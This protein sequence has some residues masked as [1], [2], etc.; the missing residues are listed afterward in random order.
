M[1]PANTRTININ[2]VKYNGQQHYIPMNFGSKKEG[3]DLKKLQENQERDQ[4]KIDYCKDNNIELL[5]IP[6]WDF[7]RIEEIL[8]CWFNNEEVVFSEEPEIVKKYK[9]DE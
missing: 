3:Y 9:K 8:D 1:I 4:I 5:I 2:C 6:Y 7:D